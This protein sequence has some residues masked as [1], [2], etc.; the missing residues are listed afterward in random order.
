MT[1]STVAVDEAGRVV[2]P[3]E[4][5]ERLGLAGPGQVTLAVEDGELRAKTPM[6]GI[7]RA[8]ALV[9]EHIAEGGS[10]VSSGELIAERRAEAAREAAR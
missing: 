3:P 1:R 5:L 2:L 6:A 7:R 9:A 10:F 4:V 8:Q